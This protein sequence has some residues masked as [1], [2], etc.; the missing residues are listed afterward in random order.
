MVRLRLWILTFV[1]MTD[2]KGCY[3][4]LGDHIDDDTVTPVDLSKPVF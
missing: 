2:G 4:P 3:A 1:R